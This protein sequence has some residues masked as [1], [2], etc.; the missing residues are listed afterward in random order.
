MAN[1]LKE[2]EKAVA[3][4]NED[5]LPG[6]SDPSKKKGKGKN[7]FY[8]EKYTNSP[9]GKRGIMK[10]WDKEFRAAEDSTTWVDEKGVLH[11][12]RKGNTPKNYKKPA[13]K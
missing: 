10:A 8:W 12:W 2:I 3:T 13:S 9:L 5:L 11:I 6:V 1:V 4:G 7:T